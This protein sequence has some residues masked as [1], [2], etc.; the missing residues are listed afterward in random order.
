MQSLVHDK[1]VNGAIPKVEDRISFKDLTFTVRKLEK[2][3][4]VDDNGDDAYYIYLTD[5]SRLLQNNFLISCEER[6]EDV[7]LAATFLLL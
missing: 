7:L 3:G 2:T 1:K 5:R 6:Y 4:Y